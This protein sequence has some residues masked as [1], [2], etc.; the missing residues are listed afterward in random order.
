MRYLIV[1]QAFACMPSMGQELHQQ[2]RNIYGRMSINLVVY[3]ES[4]KRVRFPPRPRLAESSR[5]ENTH[6]F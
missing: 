5:K 1:L 3:I 2:V 4:R 6:A